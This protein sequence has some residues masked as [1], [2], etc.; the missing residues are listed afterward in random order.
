MDYTNLK[1]SR[2]VVLFGASAALLFS[3]QNASACGLSWSPNPADALRSAEMSQRLAVVVFTGSDWSLK[4][5][6]L[7]QEVLMNVEFSDLFSQAFALANA[8]FPQRQKP[9]PELLAET[10]ALATKHNITRFPTL[11][12]L[13]PD[14]TEFG[15]IEYTGEPVQEMIQR[16][17]EWQQT[18]QKEL[19]AR[20]T[21]VMVIQPAN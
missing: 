6:Q 19:L 15:R 2:S 21:K 20:G 9:A 5:A 4:S 11:L 18:Y 16:V 17:T 8:D 12:A 3:P 1:M 7:D 13:R 14:G 10:T